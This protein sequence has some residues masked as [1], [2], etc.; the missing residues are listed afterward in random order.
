VKFNAGTQSKRR[1]QNKNRDDNTTPGPEKWKRGTRK[2][3]GG[4]EESTLD[5]EG[6]GG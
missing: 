4:R 1:V 2:R 5:D 6:E 3:K